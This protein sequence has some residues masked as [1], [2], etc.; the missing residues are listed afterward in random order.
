MLS[1]RCGSLA[2][3]SS[4]KIGMAV[5]AETIDARSRFFRPLRDYAAI[6]RQ[7][8][9]LRLST[10]RGTYWDD[11]EY[12][13]DLTNFVNE[14]M[15]QTRLAQI[16]TEIKAE[17]EKDQRIA[18]AVVTTRVGGS[19]GSVRLDITIQF[20]DDRGDEHDLTLAVSDLTV[21]MLT[22]GA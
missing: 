1:K 11:P 19:S 5:A 13:L 2:P 3:A 22:R 6:L 10:E 18:T 21:E 15:T 9:F 20:T 4:G 7:A 16:S 14:A 12:G 8:V 17:V